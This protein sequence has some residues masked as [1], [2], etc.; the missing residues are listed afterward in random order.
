MIRHQIFGRPANLTP[1]ATGVTV[2]GLFLAQLLF[3][4]GDRALG[5]ATAIRGPTHPAA[6]LAQDPIPTCVGYSVFPLTHNSPQC[7]PAS[8]PD[9]VCLQTPRAI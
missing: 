4:L 1:N 8:E 6:M 3:G 9:D 5:T 2:S 7:R